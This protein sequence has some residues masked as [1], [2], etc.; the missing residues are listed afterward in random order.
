MT[1][2]LFFSLPMSLFSRTTESKDP[3]A[4][5]VPQ[6]I[7]NAV[8]VMKGSQETQEASLAQSS[9][10]SPFLS[11]EKIQGQRSV[12][13]Q[14]AVKNNQEQP[15]KEVVEAS[16]KSSALSI[17]T[18]RKKVLFFAVGSIVVIGVG[19]GAWYFLRPT[20]EEVPV[21]LETGES[22][23][24]SIGSEAPVAILPFVPEA[25]NYL[26]VDTETVTAL[27]LRTML[28]QAG[29]KIIEAKM[30]RPVEFLLTD[31]NNNPI[32]FSRFVYL[33]NIEF[34]EELVASFEEPFSL[35]L[36]NDAGKIRLGLALTFIDA[37]KS[38]KLLTAKERLLP[39][40]FRE[41]LFQGPAVPRESIFRSGVYQDQAVRFVN[42]DATQNISFDY[43]FREKHWFIGTS[44]D[45]LRAILDKELQVRL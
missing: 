14:E 24:V 34:G 22:V 32:A 23:S 27:S 26:S 21:P 44:K 42:I 7:L 12:P 40:L 45:T 31:K 38:Q 16:Q 35:F 25:P 1:P 43:A 9:T 13:V 8:N 28:S 6:D 29:D 19:L 2:L 15:V 33:M 3:V 41:V 36:Y 4:Q 20:V 10:P 30:G 5:P 11:G 39:F 18:D 17:V 37:T